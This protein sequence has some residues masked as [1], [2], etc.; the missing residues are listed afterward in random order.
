MNTKTAV[1]DYQTAF[2][3]NQGWLTPEE[4]NKLRGSRI[5]IA[6]V[7]GAGGFQA[8]VLAR[9]GVGAFRIADPDTFELT[10]INRQI[11]A[12]LSTMGHKKVTVIDHMIRDINPE[13]SVDI[14]P[15]GLSRANM[16]A[17]LSG[18]D[19]VIDG[20]D[21]FEMDLKFLLFEECRK[22]GITVL[23][24]CPLGFGAS[25][26]VFTPTGMKYSD[27]FDIR[28]GMSQS[29]KRMA[30]T[31]GLSPNPLCLQYLQKN[32][33]S[34]S[35]RRSASVS[36]GLTLVGAI[37]GAEAVKI[38]TGKLKPISCPEVFQVDLLTQRVSKKRYRWGMRSPLQRFKKWVIKTFIM[39]NA[40]DEKDLNS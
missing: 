25:L 35:R 40:F 12:S 16:T 4:Q 11:G 36:P 22:L 18:C 5:G 37:S 24:S 13:V 30:M 9:L 28:E 29:D 31:Y 19:L 38:L 21:Y 34:A 10:N 39:K 26:I 17:F 2:D 7:G 23:T 20:I 8:Q 32:A 15:D 1:F 3:R 27:Y 33:I 14:F 6:G